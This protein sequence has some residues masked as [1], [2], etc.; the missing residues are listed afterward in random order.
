MKHA[1]P[2]EHSQ[3]TRPF[4]RPEPERSKSCEH[5]W[6]GRSSKNGHHPLQE[7]CAIHDDGQ[8]G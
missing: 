8:T 2:A 6:Q 7:A 4:H 5:D 1:N 3:E